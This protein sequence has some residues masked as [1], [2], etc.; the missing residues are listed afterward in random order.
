MSESTEGNLLYLA[1]P[2]R[3][4]T[5]IRANEDSLEDD[6][7]GLTL[8]LG[9]KHG[10]PSEYTPRRYLASRIS[11]TTDDMIEQGVAEDAD[12]STLFLL[13]L[14]RMTRSLIKALLAHILT[15][16]YLIIFRRRE[17]RVIATAHVVG[18]DNDTD[19]ADHW[20]EFLS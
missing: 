2:N 1:I 20:L 16:D 17:N 11:Q 7:N 3:S 13:E 8:L 12:L 18:A 14:L 5:R 6:V 15:E 9:L 4:L 19:F 10:Q